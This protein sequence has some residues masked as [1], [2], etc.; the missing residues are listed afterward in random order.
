MLPS[1]K[2]LVLHLRTQDSQTLWENSSRIN[3][4]LKKKVKEILLITWDTYLKNDKIITT[5]KALQH[6]WKQNNISVCLDLYINNWW[7]FKKKIPFLKENKQANIYTQPIFNIQSLEEIEENLKNFQLLQWKTN[8]YAWITW[9][10]NIKTRDYWKN[11]NKVPIKY[12]PKGDTNTTIKRN[13][14]AQTID[15]LKYIKTMWYSS[16]IMLMKSKVEDLI[17]IQNRAENNL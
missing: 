4:L 12:L 9:I 11:T 14:I 2:E 7:R 6:I 13:S 5:D 15:I 10:T 8:I 3:S 17:Y 16:Y 1:E